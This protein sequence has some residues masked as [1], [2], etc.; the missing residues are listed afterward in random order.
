MQEYAEQ[1]GIALQTIIEVARELTSHG[2][3]AAVEM[4][5]GPVQN[6]D[7]YYAGCA[8]VTLNALL[9]NADYVGGLILGGGEWKSFGVASSPYDFS[10]MFPGSL[11]SF[12]VKITRE[13]SRYE[14][15]TPVQGTRISGQKTL[16]SFYR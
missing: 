15:S 11:T 7:G 14:D 5:R 6:P 1:C 9:G 8:I 12:G 3:R 16:V 13:G 10:K 4:Y 2:K